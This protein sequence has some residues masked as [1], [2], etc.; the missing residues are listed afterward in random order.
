MTTS[1]ESKPEGTDLSTQ[2]LP[3]IPTVK[4]MEGWDQEVVL[5]W[6]KQRNFNFLKGDN[7][8]K[9]SNALIVGSIF[10]DSDVD[11]YTKICH[12][13]PGVGRALEKLADKIKEGKFI[14]RT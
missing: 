9:F 10:L 1:P 12:L 8:E 4:Q 13:P 14:P 2:K 7:L 6:I 11:F 5:Q 3:E